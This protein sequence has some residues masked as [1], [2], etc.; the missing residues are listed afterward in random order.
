MPPRNLAVLC[1]AILAFFLS[2]CERAAQVDAPNHLATDGVSFDYPGNWDVQ[3]NEVQTTGRYIQI[4][5]PGAAVAMI[6]IFPHNTPLDVK[7]YAHSVGEKM[8]QDFAH[9]KILTQGQPMTYIDVAKGREHGVDL[10]YS[11]K[12]ANVDVPHTMKIR[13]WDVGGIRVL[14]T[15]Q[16][17][18]KH[19]FQAEPGFDLITSSL[20]PF[21]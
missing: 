11:V 14:T 1:V 17:A 7:S 3:K 12:I 19:A 20:K 4:R 6:R 9:S 18:D 10:R 13:I 5:S 8:A 2:G 16:V 15:V 21:R